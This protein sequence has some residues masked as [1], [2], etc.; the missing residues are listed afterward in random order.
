MTQPTTDDTP[1]LLTEPQRAAL[2]AFADVIAPGT[3]RQPS[4]ADIDLAGAPVDLA[5]AARPDLQP[6][7]AALLDR[8]DTAD[9]SEEIRRLEADDRPAFGILMLVV[10]GAYYMDPRVRAALGYAGQTPPPPTASG[11]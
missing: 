3:A 4:A 1:P 7:L 5:L 9:P 6:P 10:A 11:D 8:L 2:R